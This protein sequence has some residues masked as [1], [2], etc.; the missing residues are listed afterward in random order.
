MGF[1]Q[2]ALA[3]QLKREIFHV[4]RL[5]SPHLVKQR[6]KIGPS[7]RPDLGGGLSYAAGMLT[8]RDGYKCVIVKPEP[9]WPPSHEHGLAGLQHQPNKR[10]Q[11]RLPTINCP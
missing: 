3:I 1:F 11:L 9:V 7:L 10:F 6:F 2:F 4:D 8:A 5:A